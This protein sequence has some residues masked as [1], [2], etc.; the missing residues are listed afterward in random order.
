MHVPRQML[1]NLKK[2]N[3]FNDYMS[4]ENSGFREDKKF[5]ARLVSEFLPSAEE[6]LSC[7]EEQSIYWNDDLE[8]VLVMIDK[9]IRKIKHNSGDE[10]ILLPLYKN[11]EDEDFVKLL[12]RKAIMNSDKYK[13]L[14]DNNTTNWEID[15]IALMD[16]LVMQLAI[17]EITE[18]PE[19]PIKVTL[20]EY[21]E[22]A[23]YYCTSKSSTFVNGI[24]D[25]VVREIRQEGMI[26]KAGRGLI[27]E[28]DYE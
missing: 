4:S 25:K 28:Q 12:F 23:K 2:W 18:F 21:I 26:N 13:E 9:T 8:Y 15:R 1:N 3:V 22:I 19:I 14:I 6:L 7:L 27:G 24:L 11:R 17:A 10:N 5:A 16:I 20:N